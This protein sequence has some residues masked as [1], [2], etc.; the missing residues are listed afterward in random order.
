MRVEAPPSPLAAALRSPFPGPS[1]EGSTS[2]GSAPSWKG[3][4]SPRPEL[5][6]QS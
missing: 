5:P 2:P 1:E 6:P 3:T 4:A